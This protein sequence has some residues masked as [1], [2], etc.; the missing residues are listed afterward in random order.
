MFLSW[1]GLGWVHLQLRKGHVCVASM[2]GRQPPRSKVSTA[3]GVA[4]CAAK[5]LE[6][7]CEDCETCLFLGVHMVL[8]HVE[9]ASIYVYLN[10]CWWCIVFEG[11][12]I[13]CNY[14]NYVC[15]ADYTV[16][17]I[18]MCHVL[19]C[20]MILLHVHSFLDYIFEYGWILIVGDLVGQTFC[21]WNMNT[22]VF[23]FAS[24]HGSPWE[25][26]DG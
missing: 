8:L 2:A 24:G 1:A 3:Q 22:S 14:V 9:G 13:I 5:C 20:L 16:I 19:P 18:S 15:Y 25:T 17:C 23:I 4:R 7:C 12:S 6:R 21:C 10:A 11:I 26:L